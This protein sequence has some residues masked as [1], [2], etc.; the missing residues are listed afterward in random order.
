M[1]KIIIGLALASS[2]LATP[3]LARDKSWYVE[4]DAGG[5]IAE[6]QTV[7]STGSYSGTAAFKAGY[8]FG[9]IVGYDFGPFRLESE[10]SYRRVALSKLTTSGGTTYSNSTGLSG[11]ADALSFMLNGLLDFGPDN[12]LQGF[13]GGGV[14]VARVQERGLQSGYGLDDSATGFAWQLLAGIRVPVSKNLDAGLKYRFFRG[15]GADNFV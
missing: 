11:S 4:G 12:G 10:A 7:T 14:G 1:R 5:V 15:E 8:D 2:A 3:A 6:D 13:V 9:G